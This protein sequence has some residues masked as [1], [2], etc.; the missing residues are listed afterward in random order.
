MTMIEDTPHVRTEPGW[1]G[2]FTR[3]QAGGAMPNGTRI[4]KCNTVEGADFHPDGTPGVVLG[5]MV[6]PE[7]ESYIYFVEWAPQPRVAMAVVGHRI[8]AADV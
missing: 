6:V 8:R 3:A 5:S 7:T 1:F 2:N 4:V